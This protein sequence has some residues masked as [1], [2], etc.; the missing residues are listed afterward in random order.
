MALHSLLIQNLRIIEHLELSLAQNA[1][2]F[3]GENGAGK[4]SILEGVDFLSRGR[5]FR[6]RT[7][8]PILRNESEHVTV[9]GK[10]VDREQITTL[11]IQKSADEMKLHHDEEK[12]NS[13]SRHASNLPVVA[14]HPDSHQIIQGGSRHRR[15]YLDWSAF[16]VKPDFLQE[17]R[18]FNKCLRQRNNILRKGTDMKSEL[19]AWTKE[20]CEFSK[21]ITY[22]R[23]QIF[24]EINDMFL[25]YS[26]KLLPEC[27]I[28]L[29]FDKG[30]PD[31]QSL[32]EALAASYEQEHKNK[33]TRWG[34]QRADIKIKLNQKNAH[35]SASR[36]QQ[37]LIAASLLLAQ[38]NNLQTYSS[39]HC[40]VLLDDIRAELDNAH[41][42]A[43]FTSL[44]DLKCQ[45]FIS[46]IEPDD[47][48]LGGWEDSKMFHVEHG[49]CKPLR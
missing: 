14:M 12:I 45:V 33:T 35:L 2:L 29:D 16:H 13:I 1:N 8:D 10:V 32:E 27:R 7:L 41:A 34:P 30:W 44:Q 37:K 15:H 39:R 26:S 3:I 47:V 48:N 49:K 38:I 11:G 5:T 18:K 17:W 36:G 25:Q 40:V 24:Q 4:T 21:K 23:S 20:F 46:A 28:E 42:H 19:T 6:S 31:A 22:T 9:S 43:L